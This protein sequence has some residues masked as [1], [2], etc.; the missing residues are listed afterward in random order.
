[1]KSK[2]FCLFFEDN[3]P[4]TTAQQ[5]KFSYRT[6]RTYEPPKLKAARSLYMEK[7]K[8]YIPEW[9]FTLQNWR[10]NHDNKGK[11]KIKKKID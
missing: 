4:T 1:M 11:K 2:Y 6:K 5:R 8:E 9:K 3:I 10:I 7:L